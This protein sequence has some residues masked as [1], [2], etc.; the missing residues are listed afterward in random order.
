MNMKDKLVCDS[1]LLTIRLCS[2]NMSK[3]TSHND[4]YSV[5]D[6]GKEGP[7]QQERSYQKEERPIC[8]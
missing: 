8:F 6:G 2:R 3:K 5:V 4:P 7:S 1:G